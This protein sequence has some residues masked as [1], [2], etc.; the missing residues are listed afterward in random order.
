MLVCLLSLS[1]LVG[2]SKTEQDNSTT[3]D[4]EAETGT[5]QELTTEAEGEEPV[6]KADV[7]IAALTG[8]TAM[9]MAKVMTD[10]AEG[11]TA[12]NYN[13][14]IAGTADEI[15]ADLIKGNIDIAAVPCNL[16]SVLYNKTEGKIRVAAINTL[17]VLY[18]L[19]NGDSIQS[20]EDLKGKTIYSMGKG[21]TPEYTLNF[22]L[23]SYGLDPEK[24]VTIEYKSEAAEVVSVLAQ[25][26]GAIGMLPQPQ[27]TVAMTQ[28]DKLRVALDVTEQWEAAVTN[29]STVTTGVVVVNAQFAEENPEVLQAFLEEYRSSVT[30]VNENAKEAAAMLEALDIFKAAIAEKAIPMC[31]ISFI[32]GEEMKTKITGYLEVLY[33]QNPQTVGGKLPGDDFYMTEQ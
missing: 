8:P 31:N 25:E 26:E 12:N 20:V 19:E 27:V 3:T 16:A 9:G 23:S 22:M 29:G 28:N 10:A 1:V 4:T 7:T 33:D 18:I 14:T 11:T 2:C 32:T 30:F 21:T 17:G 13:F 5:Q 24:D 6:E 15:T